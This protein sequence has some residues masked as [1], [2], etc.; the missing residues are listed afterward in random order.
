MGIS[1]LLNG[2]FGFAMLM[3]LLFCMPS[4]IQGT[5]NADTLYPL[6]SI[7]SY[8]VGS[9]AGGTAMVRPR[10]FGFSLLFSILRRYGRTRVCHLRFPSASRLASMA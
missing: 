5:L 7:Y 2:T 10:C 8:A 9:N 4:D 3:A 1:T 6:T